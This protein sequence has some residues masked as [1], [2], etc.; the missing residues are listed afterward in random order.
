MEK[1]NIVNPGGGLSALDCIAIV[2]VAAKAFGFCDIT[3]GQ[4]LAPLWMPWAFLL[5][6]GCLASVCQYAGR[7]WGWILCGAALA[8]GMIV[9]MA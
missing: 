8:A 4:A 7:F 3:W 5:W 2:L 1:K 9:A 6:L